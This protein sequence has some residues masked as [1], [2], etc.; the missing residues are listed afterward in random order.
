MTIITKFVI[1]PEEEAAMARVSVFFLTDTHRVLPAGLA[2]REI[3]LNLFSTWEKIKSWCI[4]ISCQCQID[5]S[6]G[7]DRKLGY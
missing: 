5:I 2:K 6:V 7:L 1:S 4:F 3:G